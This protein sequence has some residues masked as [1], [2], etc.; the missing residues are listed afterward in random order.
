MRGKSDHFFKT[1][2]RQIFASEMFELEIGNLTK[3]YR[4][5]FNFKQSFWNQD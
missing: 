4:L 1:L 3:S 5:F 2:A